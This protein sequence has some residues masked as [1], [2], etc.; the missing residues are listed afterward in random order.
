MA[1]AATLAGA[2]VISQVRYQFGHESPPGFTAVVLLDES[3]CSAHA[4]ADEGQIALDVFTCGSTDPWKVLEFLREELDLGQVKVH[5][6]PRFHA[7]NLGQPPP[8]PTK[9]VRGCVEPS[10]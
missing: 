5:E 10:A 4:Y 8:E 7:A 9:V 1:R 3:H 6:Q 2:N